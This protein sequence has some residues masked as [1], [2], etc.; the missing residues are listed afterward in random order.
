M[1]FNFQVEIINV[2]INMKYS[3]VIISRHVRPVRTYDERTMIDK[4]IFYNLVLFAMFVSYI[5]ETE[6]K[7]DIF[8]ELNFRFC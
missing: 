7:G 6:G 2:K 3:L 5:K 1:N 4:I 8:L